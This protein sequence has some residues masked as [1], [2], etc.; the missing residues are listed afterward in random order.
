MR[1]IER[2]LTI[3]SQ[4]FCG[5]SLAQLSCIVGSVVTRLPQTLAAI[6]K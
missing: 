6:C 5:I 1:H 4:K 3:I 2:R